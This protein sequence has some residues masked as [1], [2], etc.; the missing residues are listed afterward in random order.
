MIR[1][2]TTATIN[3]ATASSS[4]IN[5]NSSQNSLLHHQN[6]ESTKNYSQYL[7]QLKSKD[8]RVQLKAAKNF[9]ACLINELKQVKPDN[10]TNFVDSLIPEIRELA[11]ENNQNI[12]DK[13]ACIYI[14]TSI[15]NLDNIN[16]KVRKKH[17]TNFLRMLRNLLACSDQN[18]IHMASRA[19]GKY[20]LAGVECDVEF[21]SGLEFLRIESK[22][23]QGI[24]LVKELALASPSRLFLNSELFYDNIMSAVCDHMPEIRHKAIELFRLS[25]DITTK[26]EAATVSYSSN[27][28]QQ[29]NASQRLRR[30]STNSSLSSSISYQDQASFTF[31]SHMN[32]SGNAG[33]GGG[34]GGPNSSMKQ[35]KDSSFH[36]CFR[37]S[38]RELETLLKEI[39]ASASSGKS[40][41]S[42]NNQQSTREDKIH[43]YLLVILE[44]VKFSCLEFEQQ[45]EK[46]LSSYNL[47]H[48]QQQP[49]TTV[50]STTTNASN[51]SAVNNNTLNSCEE[52][53]AANLLKLLPHSFF[54]PLH[55]NDPFMF[56][57]KSEKISVTLESRVCAQ[58]VNDKFDQIAKI[59]LSTVRTLNLASHLASN[60]NQPNAGA[61]QNGTLLG[62]TSK[63]V[64]F[65][66]IKC[67]YE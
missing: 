12:S 10:E 18:V 41:M 49:S 40:T 66:S 2:A 37:N 32:T 57:F 19:M 33:G 23:Y 48:Q 14:I 50:H 22:R 8:Q 45:I 42:Q 55:A 15:I 38:I 20:A 59:C 62:N 58:L 30:T 67:Y 47:Y 43:G 60:A 34:G 3:G 13:Q 31:G 61:N 21:K 36:Q 56:L 63:K 1:S 9:Y 28:T 64:F 27:S 46:Y 16:V 5:T 29:Q 26:R 4:Q 39:G 6:Q 44:I 51:A 17:Q 52:M 25:L 7:T 53:H 65:L 35:T 11:N 24:L 54:D